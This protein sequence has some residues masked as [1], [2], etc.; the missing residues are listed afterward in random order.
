[1]SNS[2]TAIQ[3]NMILM[4][5]AMIVFSRAVQDFQST[6]NE[7]HPCR[8]TNAGKKQFFQEFPFWTDF[9]NVLCDCGK[10]HI[11]QEFPFWKREREIHLIVQMRAFAEIASQSKPNGSGKN[12]RER[13]TIEIQRRTKTRQALRACCLDW[14]Q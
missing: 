1:M 8:L 5:L 3:Q 4:S 2:N 14:I 6:P 7:R 10:K 9:Y 13:K 12:E 11:F